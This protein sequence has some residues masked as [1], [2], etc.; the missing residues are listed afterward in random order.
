[1]LSV[2][3]VSTIPRA[4]LLCKHAFCFTVRAQRLPHFLM[5]SCLCACEDVRRRAGQNGCSKDWNALANRAEDGELRCCSDLLFNRI[6]I[7]T[8]HNRLEVRA[9]HAQ[10]G[11]LRN[12]STFQSCCGR[13]LQPG[14][15]HEV[16]STMGL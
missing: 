15:V 2:A 4:A 10:L 3:S 1:M 5:H 13:F 9:S 11:H 6:T 7:I 12:R 14:R 16:M 8:H